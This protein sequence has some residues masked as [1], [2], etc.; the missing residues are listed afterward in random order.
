MWR[1]GAV[2]SP[3]VH[4]VVGEARCV[5]CRR[6]A[7]VL[8]PAC[9]ADLRPADPREAP[10]G[11]DR[12]LCAL[13]YSGAARSLVL[14]L[15][16]RGRKGAALPLATR[17]VDLLARS[18]VRA[19]AITWVP[20]R[21]PETRRRGFDHAAVLAGAVGRRVGL[22]VRPLLE[23]VGGVAD[24]TTLSAA[25]RWANLEGA[26]I[27]RPCSEPALVVDD[28]VTTGATLSTCAQALV[29]AG[30]PRGRG[31]HRLQCPGHY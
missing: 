28:L 27:A 20:G 10:P 11:V 29:E 7:G 21:P 18:G 6:R 26:F 5:G 9:S 12:I 22:P 14:D 25:E 4:A 16:L 2:R 13:D 31:P 23:R 3:G 15:K 19:R 1:T 17:M 8:C 24:Q 30:L